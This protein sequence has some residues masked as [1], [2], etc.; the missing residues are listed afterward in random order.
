MSNL[1]EEQLE[2]NLNITEK[3]SELF[4]N[5]PKWVDEELFSDI[6]NVNY[7]CEGGCA[8]GAYMPSM[9]TNE[10]NKTMLI[11]GND[12][13][14]FIINNDMQLPN[15]DNSGW[16]EINSSFLSCAVEILAYNI[17]AD[18]EELEN[19]KEID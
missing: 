12:V 19:E 2:K 16:N 9:I 5:L 15:T 4:S 14:H 11:H 3:Q 1:T 8:S 13:V 10:A 6:E 17:Q 18:Y 7:I